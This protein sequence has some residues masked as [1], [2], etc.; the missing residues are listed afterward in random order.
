MLFVG[1]EYI[2][3]TKSDAFSYNQHWIVPQRNSITVRV[4]A[5]NDIHIGLSKAYG[6]TNNTIKIAI[7]AWGNTKS[8]IATGVDVSRIFSHFF[9]NHWSCCFYVPKCS[10]HGSLHGKHRVLSRS[11][12]LS[13]ST[14]F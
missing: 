5:C 1:D 4:Q 2:L 11:H 6:D 12:D 9:R 13:H 14:S 10:Q 7:G 8:T 3:Q